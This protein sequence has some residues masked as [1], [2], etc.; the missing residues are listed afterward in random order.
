M[1]VQHV[2]LHVNGRRE[3]T[4]MLSVMS[5]KDKEQST[6]LNCQTDVFRHSNIRI[7]NMGGTSAQHRL[8]LF[9]CRSRWLW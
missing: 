8:H 9:E 6:Y 3:I 2:L 4:S 5:V 7:I 1:R